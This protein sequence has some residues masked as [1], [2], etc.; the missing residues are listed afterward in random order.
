MNRKT[1]RAHRAAWQ[2]YRSL[3]PDDMHVCH[4]CDVR[5][6]VNP[7]HLFLGTNADNIEDCLRKRRRQY[8][9][10]CR[11]GHA[12]TEINTRY[13]VDGHRECRI[14]DRLRR[15]AKDY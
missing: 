11:N 9:Y 15:S 14:C 1:I 7:D 13:H 2:L 12:R 6:C 4:R 8:D 3:I 5:L 10:T